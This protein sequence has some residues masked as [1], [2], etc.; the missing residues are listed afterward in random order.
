[1]CGM[2]VDDKDERS[3]GGVRSEVTMSGVGEGE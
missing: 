2:K 1:M 3:D